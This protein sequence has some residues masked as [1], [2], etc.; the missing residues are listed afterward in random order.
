[1]HT[2]AHFF[3]TAERKIPRPYYFSEIM[4][5]AKRSRM[6]HRETRGATLLMV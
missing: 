2:P 4:V 1:M 3:E 5:A 6:K